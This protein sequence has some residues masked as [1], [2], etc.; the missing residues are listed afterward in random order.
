MNRPNIL[1]IH[2]HDTGRYIQPYGYAIPTPNLRKLA[3]TG[4]VF[5]Q[6][7][8]A[9]PT[10][11]PSRAALLTGMCP[12]SAGQFGLTNRGFELP[13]TSKHIVNTLKPVGYRTALFGIQ[14]IRHDPA[15]IGYDYVEKNDAY[16]GRKTAQAAAEY[17]RESATRRMPD[18]RMPEG[19]KTG[20]THQPFFLSVGFFETHRPFPGS[21]F[22]DDPRFI[23]PSAP[24]P[25][26]PETRKDMAAFQSSAAELDRNMGIVFQALEENGLTE[27]TLVI[28]TTDHGIAFPTMKCRLTNHGT[29]VMLIIRGPGKRGSRMRGPGK[30][31]TGTPCP[32]GFSGG[33]TVDAL[34][35]H[36]DIFPT[37]C[38]LLEIEPPSWL[39]G[40][41]MMPLMTGKKEEINE[42]VYSEVNYH[43]AY[44][45]QRSVR[46]KRWNYIR[47]YLDRRTPLLANCDRSPS[48]DLYLSRGW[49]ESVLDQEQLY[50]L[51]FDPN[52]TNNLAQSPKHRSVLEEM[53][54][55]LAGWMERTNDPLLTGEVPAPRTASV[56]RPDDID[57]ADVWT[58]TEKPANQV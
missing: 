42:E 1:Y 2:S 24:L 37:I 16:N 39:E 28:C 4:V 50:D 36:I 40:K 17:I 51:F 55:R 38:D 52:E 27:H 5:R 18:D 14:H 8:N 35:S 45:P 46:T 21:A 7:F 48:K 47:R 54:T 34:V 20:D 6:A 29:G 9:A 32:D 22:S 31:V 19:R 13:D 49:A 25:D 53:R 57:P 30:Q 10:C 26:T 11:S 33:R 43:C 41:S 58:Y 23:R 44:E 3:E 15:S 56:S 12:H